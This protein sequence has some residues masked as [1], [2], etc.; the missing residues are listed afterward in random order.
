MCAESVATSVLELY[1]QLD[2]NGKPEYP[3]Y[4]VLAGV[5]ASVNDSDYHTVALAT[6]TKCA[7]ESFLSESGVA[8]A[9]SHA[10]VL[11]RRAFIRYLFQCL[12]CCL[13]FPAFE[14]SARCPFRLVPGC[15]RFCVKEGWKF[16][17]Y[18]S[19]S[20]CGDA[21]VYERVSGRSF[22]GK[23]A[24]ICS[25]TEFSGIIPGAVRLKPGTAP[26]S[27]NK[28]SDY[29]RVTSVNNIRLMSFDI[30]GR[31]DIPDRCRTLSMSCSDKI[32]KWNFLGI[33][34][35]D[36][37]II[38]LKTLKYFLNYRALL[39]HLIEPI[40]IRGFV[41]GSDPFGLQGEQEEALRRALLSRVP[42][43]PCSRSRVFLCRASFPQGKC[44]SEE[45]HNE[46]TLMDNN[47]SIAKE[48]LQNLQPFE[49][50]INWILSVGHSSEMKFARAGGT[51]EITLSRT[52]ISQGSSLKA[53]KIANRVAARGD[54]FKGASR[55]CNR[56]FEP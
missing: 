30:I 45:A 4:T 10:E 44:A 35:Y 28:L 50:S 52:G 2:R 5:V 39:S 43:D 23:K 7:G 24:R 32:A 21:S 13:S 31:H 26:R 14:E 16:Y 17:I 3:R 46:L 18:S 47:N 48:I 33:Q 55:L 12:S 6:G 42:G 36:W 51:I 41:V 29:Y 22:S 54:A 38:V 56:Y 27:Q 20:P 25:A 53:K 40:F 9:D 1:A 49:L 15:T 37:N 8:L 19:D 34:G 11:A